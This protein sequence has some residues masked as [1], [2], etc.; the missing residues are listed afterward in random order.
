MYFLGIVSP[1]T[2]ESGTHCVLQA[3]PELVI[4]QLQPPCG[5]DDRN[6][7]A[8]LVFKFFLKFKNI[9]LVMN[10]AYVY[11]GILYLYVCVHVCVQ[12]L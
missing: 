8:H 11:L 4:L 3:D 9:F 10:K 7:P 12:V 5:W 1:F 2:L 6:E